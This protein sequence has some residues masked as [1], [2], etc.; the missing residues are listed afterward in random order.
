MVYGKN[1]RLPS[2]FFIES[3]PMNNEIEF[4]HNFRNMMSNLKPTT[5]A[6]HNTNQ[7]FFIQKELMNSSHVFVRNDTV[8]SSLQQPFDGPYE[9]LKKNDKFFKININ[10]KNKNISIDRIKA[11]FIENSKNTTLTQTTSEPEIYTTR[12]GR[13]VKF[14]K[15][16]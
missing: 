2:E 5:T 10:G 3:K 9:V 6:H 4:I 8:R 15:Y 16:N 1:L 13:K 12:S 14:V 11:A 7:K